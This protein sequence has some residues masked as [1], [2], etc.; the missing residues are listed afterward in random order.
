M[1]APGEDFADAGGGFGFPPGGGFG[2]EAGG[3]VAG[4]FGSVEGGGESRP[5]GLRE[6]LLG[7]FGKGATQ[8]EL[9]SATQRLGKPCSPVLER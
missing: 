2:E 6:N 7:Q 5:P 4:G 3:A 1:K 8:G 9:L